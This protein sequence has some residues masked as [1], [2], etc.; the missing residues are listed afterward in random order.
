MTY[1]RTKFITG[2]DAGALMGVSPYK[3]AYDVYLDKIGEGV[4]V[5]DNNAMLWGRNLERAVAKH[6]VKQHPE[7][8]LIKGKEEVGENLAGTPDYMLKTT[9]IEG[10]IYEAVLEIKTADARNAKMWVE[11]APLHYQFQVMHYMYLTG[12]PYGY[13]AVL[14]GGNDYREY[15]IERNDVVIETMLEVYK[16]FW[17]A[18]ETRTPP[19]VESLAA[20]EKM[21]SRASIGKEIKLP[22]SGS[23]LC[24]QLLELKA[25]IKQ[26]EAVIESIETVIKN[27][28]KDAESALTADMLY[29]VEWKQARRETLDTKRLKAERPEIASEY[30]KESNYRLFKIKEIGRR[31]TK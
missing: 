2:S 7:Y 17:Q 16:N 26:K 24:K 11:D 13:I 23:D 6:F 27:E 4:A 3:T 8:R 29:A 28:M 20:I 30:L 9:G 21:Y 12:A 19:A 1:D 14:I 10:R 15:R 5:E 18:V 31:L 25:E 22:D